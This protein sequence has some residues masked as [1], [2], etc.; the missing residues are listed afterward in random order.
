[1]FFSILAQEAASAGSNSQI[2]IALI[3]IVATA[4]GGLVYSVKN[5]ALNKKILEDSS[6]VVGAVNHISPG[7]K[8]LYQLTASYGMTLEYIKEEISQIKKRHTE[9]DTKFDSA[10][11]HAQSSDTILLQISSTVN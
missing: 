8:N 2:L 4:V 10:R 5:N 1:M 7:E 9:F 11:D 6:A 3:G